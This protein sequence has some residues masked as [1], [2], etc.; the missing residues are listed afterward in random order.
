MSTENWLFE[1]VLVVISSIR[2][3]KPLRIMDQSMQRTVEAIAKVHLHGPS[4]REN[5]RG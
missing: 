2:L 5:R 3:G 1:L 4:E